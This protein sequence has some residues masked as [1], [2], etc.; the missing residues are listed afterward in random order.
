MVRNIKESDYNYIIVRL[1]EWWGGRDMAAMLPRLFFQHFTDSSFVFED[2]AKILGFLVGFKSQSLEH[3]GYI[4]FVGVDP[5]HRNKS[6]ARSLYQ[7]FF[8]Y[9]RFNHINRVEC[10]TSPINKA[11]IAFHHQLG[12]KASSYDA[13]GNPIAVKNYDSPGE[14]RITFTKHLL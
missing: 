10:I 6:I 9:C 5:L 13:H 2:S 4:H 1:N 12:F 11:S 8:N 3:V 14:S 7:E